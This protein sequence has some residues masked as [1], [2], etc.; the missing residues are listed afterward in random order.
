MVIWKEWSI[1]KKVCGLL[2]TFFC[3]RACSF[4]WKLFLTK[5]SFVKHSIKEIVQ[6]NKRSERKYGTIKVYFLSLAPSCALFSA[7]FPFT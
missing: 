7:L 2:R 6:R 5:F 4:I 3:G 1:T